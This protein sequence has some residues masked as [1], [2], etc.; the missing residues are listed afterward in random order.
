MSTGGFLVPLPQL[1][2]F[3]KY[4][5]HY[6]DYQS[7]VFGGMMVNE[8][9][10]RTYDCDANCN[11]S[12][13]TG[14]LQCKIPGTAVL[15]RYG[16]ALNKQGEWAGILVSIIVAYRLLGWLVMWARRR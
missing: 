16:Y 7:W 9:K 10:G 5:F 2:P 13:P 11:C 3:Y 6:I 1:N 4:V 14:N 12:F 8:F 15:E